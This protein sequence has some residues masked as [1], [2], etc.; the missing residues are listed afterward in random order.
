M[1]SIA[2][3]ERLFITKETYLKIA[4][5]NLMKQTCLSYF[6]GV[7]LAETSTT[8]DAVDMMATTTK[9]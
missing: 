5:V 8:M 1:Y 4:K 9:D 2:Y 7:K 3:D 6:H